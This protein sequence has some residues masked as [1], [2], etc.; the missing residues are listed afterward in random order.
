[1]TWSPSASTQP[2][3]SDA[4]VI[5]S[6]AEAISVP[7]AIPAD[8]F[9]LHAPLE[10]MARGALLPWVAP[11]HRDAAL[12]NIASL[13]T[14]YAAFSD[15]I[16]TP[17]IVEFPSCAAAVHAFARAIRD[18]DLD[19]TDSV[20]VWFVTHCTP[21]KIATLL[22]DVVAP[23]LAAA[24]HG[25]IFLYLLPRVHAHRGPALAMLRPLARELARHSQL[26]LTWQNRVGCDTPEGHP[27]GVAIND[28][29]ALRAALEAVPRLG[30]P[31]SD[32]IFPIMHQ[33]VANGTVQDLLTDAVATVTIGGARAVVLRAAAAAML[34]EHSEHAAY[35]WSH[36]LT[37]PQ[38]VLGLAA[39]SQHPRRLIAIATTYAVGFRAAFSKVPITWNY[40][41]ERVNFTTDQALA[42]G[43]D[44]AV[45][46]AAAFHE[47]G[48][49]PGA[50]RRCLATRAAIQSDA[51]LVKY[52][53]ASFDAASDDPT[54]AATYIAAAASLCS[55]WTHRH[56]MTGTT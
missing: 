32:F 22:A 45:V 23:S 30:L 52:V 11:E 49:N 8:S 3:R 9:V 28:S 13:A 17:R 36:A 41:P 33:V 19:T 20:A 31:G 34:H 39:Q 21:T 25:S 37:M 35:G 5:S 12:R 43:A 54:C 29:E 53:L 40:A 6:V 18:N 56:A 27:I 24:A 42:S 7:R 4:E 48:T 46:A 47:Y 10:L 55:Y 15:G 16:G 51:H 26:E 44:R 2:N 50:V 38:A 1:M 14:D